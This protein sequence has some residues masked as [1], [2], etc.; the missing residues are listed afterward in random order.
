MKKL[1]FIAAL[2]IGL[3]SYAQ[4]QS[5]TV[6]GVVRTYSGI[7]ST[8]IQEIQSIAGSDF[9]CR[10]LSYYQNTTVTFK[11]RMLM[12]GRSLFPAV[13]VRG[14]AFGQVLTTTSVGNSGR[15]IYI[16][17]ENGGPYSAMMLRPSGATLPN[18]V[19]DANEG[20]LVSV[21]GVVNSFQGH[22]QVDRISYFERIDLAANSNQEGRNA[23]TVTSAG[24]LNDLNLR[25]ILTTGEAYES[26]FVELRDLQVVRLEEFSSNRWNIFLADKDGNRIALSDRLKAGTSPLRSAPDGIGGTLNVPPIGATYEY[27]KGLIYHAKRLPA[28]TDGTDCANDGGGFAT[29]ASASYQIMPFSPNH[30]KLGTAPPIISD[31]TSSPLVP[32]PTQAVTINATIQSLD[33]GVAVKYA[34]L[35]YAVGDTLNYKVVDMQNAV[36]TLNYS[37]TIPTTGF[38][39][40]KIVYYFI[41]A[42]DNRSIGLTNFT[43]NV[44]LAGAGTLGV[45]GV[46]VVTIPG[47][48][49]ILLSPQDISI[50]ASEVSVAGFNPT[51]IAGFIKTIAGTNGGI[52]VQATIAFDVSTIAGFIKTIVGS[53]GFVFA[54]VNT[55]L[56][57][58]RGFDK[59]ATFVVRDG[60]L[61]IF[62]VQ[63]T[64]F[65]N[66]NS[67]FVGKTVTLTGIAT[68]T[69]K[70]LGNVVLQQKEVAS[71]AGIFLDFSQVLSN[72]KLGDEITVIGDVQERTFTI[73]TNVRSTSSN[74]NIPIKSSGNVITPLVVD[75]NLFSGAYNFDKHERY[76]AMLVEAANPDAGKLFV[77]DTNADFSLS[78]NGFVNNFGEYRIGNAP[79]DGAL[80][81]LQ[82]TARNTGIAG[83]RVLAGR[84]T[85]TTV[86]NS[87]NFSLVSARGTNINN[88]TVNGI[89]VKYVT[90]NNLLD[91]LRGIMQHSFSNM[92]LLPRNNADAIG[93]SVILPANPT[94]V[95][96][97]GSKV[98]FEIAPNP[99]EG[100]FSLILP[101]GDSFLFEV[102]D[103][104]GKSILKGISQGNVAVN[105]E[106]ENA[107]VYLVRVTNTITGSSSVKRLIIK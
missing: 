18:D 76:E 101:I 103:I 32:S 9:P 96:E 66:G 86:L 58:G 107:G 59:P 80:L 61:S 92:K 99:N 81:T 5:V 4:I 38:E 73:L 69:Q 41:Q 70:D 27:V 17:D 93:S 47:S 8:T 34:K 26:D 102:S 10:D 89:G 95:V 45:P 74:P 37:A 65:S 56:G 49:N 14:V 90:T 1:S 20:D 53:N 25:N 71:F 98:A 79:V 51:T 40:G 48:T 50:P 62:D 39:N 72:V 35:Y 100:S 75:P 104:L 105:L 19:L 97:N 106:G 11:G 52:L 46:G 31:V 68:A 6:A 91:R 64:P 24:L 42:G 36:G 82:G 2:L 57:L 13:T 15:E 87:Y 43:P 12:S 29:F 16:K 85:S 78:N 67:L 3:S 63:Y 60:G 77:V 33:A 23:V 21:T 28:N 7:I 94:S 22:T 30:L 55:I 54:Q 88:I 84:N 83:L 44:Y